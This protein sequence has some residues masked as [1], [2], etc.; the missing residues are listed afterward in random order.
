MD[1]LFLIGHLVHFNVLSG[2][3]IGIHIKNCCFNNKHNNLQFSKQCNV[4]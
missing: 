3:E 1:E 2:G 4:I